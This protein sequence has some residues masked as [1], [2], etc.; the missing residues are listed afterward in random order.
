MTMRRDKKKKPLPELVVYERAWLSGT[1][2]ALLRRLANPRG[3]LQWLVEDFARR[4]NYLD[5]SQAPEILVREVTLFLLY[6]NG[7]GTMWLGKMP[8]VSADELRLLS[9]EIEAGVGRFADGQEWTIIVKTEDFGPLGISRS[10]RRETIEL[11]R[12]RGKSIVVASWRS[13]SP[14]RT[15]LLSFRLAA[16]ELVASAHGFLA[17]CPGCAMVFVRDVLRQ[18]YCTAKCSTVSRMREHRR[19]KRGQP[20]EPIPKPRRVIDER[21]V[22]HWP[23]K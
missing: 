21:G 6:Q 14:A 20:T 10:V 9:Q 17:K 4:R 11:G 12:D 15:F 18:T 8:R 23:G 7:A 16:Q 13:R 1:E 3:R 2:T 5:P 19:R 22:V